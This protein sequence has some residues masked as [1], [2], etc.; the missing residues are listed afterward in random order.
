MEILLNY[1]STDS[2]IISPS[3]EYSI[4]NIAEMINIQFG[5]KIEFDSGYSDGQYQKTADN[6]RLLS[7]LPN[8]VFTSLECGIFETVDWFIREYK[9]IRK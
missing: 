8:F 2:I 3:Q 4:Y 7:F 6:L 1:N 5:N 9:N